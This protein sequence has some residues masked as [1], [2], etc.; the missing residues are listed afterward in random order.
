MAEEYVSRKEFDNLR[1]EVD[2]IKKEM[3]E[4]MKILQAID[5]KIDVIDAKIATSEEID[6]LKITPMQKELSEIKDNN[7]WLWRT[8]VGTM[9][10]IAIKIIFDVTA[11]RG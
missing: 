9:I 10:T 4:S 2:N 6:N 1:G 5:K 7:K 3:N 8:V 11:L